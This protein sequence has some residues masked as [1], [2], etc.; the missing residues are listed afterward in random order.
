MILHRGGGGVKK[1]IQSTNREMRICMYVITEGAE[2]YLSDELFILASQI[3][4]SFFY[5]K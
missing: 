4:F 2:P 1:V 5:L 3:F